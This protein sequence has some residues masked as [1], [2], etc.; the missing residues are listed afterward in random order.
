MRQ[1]IP[2]R[3]MLGVGASCAIAALACAGGQARE[4][5]PL[6]ESGSIVTLRR[7]DRASQEASALVEIASR[8]GDAQSIASVAL[9]DKAPLTQQ[10]AFTR[11]FLERYES[12]PLVDQLRA[13]EQQLGP[14]VMQAVFGAVNYG[15]YHRQQAQA[16]AEDGLWREHLGEKPRWDVL[17]EAVALYGL[18]RYMP[19]SQ[20]QPQD[21]APLSLTPPVG[22]PQ[23]LTQQRSPSPKHLYFSALR[24]ATI[25]GANKADC[26][27][28][29]EC[30]AEAINALTLKVF[31][32]KIYKS[33][34]VLSRRELKTVLRAARIAPD[35]QVLGVPARALYERARP[36]F[37]AA[38]YT[39]R[40]LAPS[41][42]HKPLVDRLNAEQALEDK[43]DV[44]SVYYDEALYNALR[45]ALPPGLYFGEPARFWLRRFAD[46]TAADLA[47]ALED[48][49]KAFD[50]P[51]HREIYRRG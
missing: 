26:E 39:Y 18:A 7:M 5:A 6:D 45:A 24:L 44:W 10:L 8:E 27:S 9:D 2:G 15:A 49:I 40:Y 33:P 35:D 41:K 50:P 3:W 28:Q 34:G 11:A 21:L 46:G 1:R 22:R 16:Q 4:D 37:A 12:G 42:V 47:K 23:R 30:D 13:R 20:P 17:R 29:P 14:R 19:E 43:G 48:T 36:G 32:V 51:L 25:T 38:A 31:G